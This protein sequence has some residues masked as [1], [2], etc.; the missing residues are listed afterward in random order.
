MTL[1]VGT[2]TYI[3]EADADTYWTDRG[4]TDWTGLSSANKEI[5][6]IKATDWIDRKYR[7]VGDKATAAQR[8]QW[9][10]CYAYVDGFLIDDS[11]IPWQI[12]EATA[13]VADRIRTDLY[14]TT[15]IVTD[16]SAVTMQKVDVITVQYDNAY[17]LRGQ[18]VF[19]DVE[20]LLSRLRLGAGK[21][22]RS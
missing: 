12:E 17:R 10:R 22:V 9:P 15:G 19:G 21:L 3:S 1:T 11:T 6:L 13:I 20:Q 7:F 16:D 8:L 4:N 5:F 14:D 2:N 18:T